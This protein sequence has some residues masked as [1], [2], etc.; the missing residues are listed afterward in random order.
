M[1][2][3]Y[4]ED[5]DIEEE[6]DDENKSIEKFLSALNDGRSHEEQ[7]LLI[8]AMFDNIEW[9]AQMSILSVFKQYVRDLMH[10]IDDGYED[11]QEYLQDELDDLREKIK[12]FN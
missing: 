5:F 6:T 10:V 8:R 4:Y 9:Q 1:N 11:K 2:E 3:E 7:I 12:R